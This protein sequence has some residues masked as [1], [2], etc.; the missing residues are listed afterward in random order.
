[1]FCDAR[2]YKICYTACR[3]M[4]SLLKATLTLIG[5]II[6]A[7]IF[8]LPEAFAAVGIVPASLIFWTMTA[9]VLA[10]HLMMVDIELASKK[11]IRLAGAVRRW[12]GEPAFTFAALTYPC[13]LIGAS[14]VYLVLGASF[15]TMLLTPLG[16]PPAPFILQTAFWLGGV[17]VLVG[18]LRLLAKVEAW[19]TWLLLV[20]LSLAIGWAWQ[21]NGIT[22]APSHFALSLSLFGVCLFSLGGIPGMGE[23]VE[24]AGRE[25]RR[26][27]LATI[28]GTLVAALVSWLF[29]LT[30]A[31][32]SLLSSSIW[33]STLMAGAGFLA[34]ATSYIVVTQDL[35]ATLMFDLNLHTREALALAA[36][37]PLVVTY[38]MAPSVFATVS[39]VG[40]VFGGAD[41]V[42]VA[43]TAASIYARKRR[44]RAT[45]LE[46]I[47]I[48]VGAVYL[49]GVAYWVWQRVLY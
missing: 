41:G 9:V 39:I 25:R 15:L 45:L 34:V 5:T 49:F 38:M 10:T 32:T 6:G 46:G 19:A 18:G 27:Q 48:L 2:H 12:L 4:R 3:D 11:P 22:S 20:A 29:A 23:V 14:V 28:I 44:S 43:L 36:G 47:C 42:L 37:I 1:M 17:L 33:F 7:G 35:R 8:V 21:Q 13:H 24:M 26:A 31:G 16:I 30:M 40:T